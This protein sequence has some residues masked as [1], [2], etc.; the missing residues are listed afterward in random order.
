MITKIVDSNGHSYASRM[1]AAGAYANDHTL[2]FNSSTLSMGGTIL[3]DVTPE[4]KDFYHKY[5]K[6]YEAQDTMVRREQ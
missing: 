3:N 1:A 2:T 4:V 5:I 6:R